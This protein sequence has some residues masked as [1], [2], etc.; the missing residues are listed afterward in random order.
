[1]VVNVTR[2][3]ASPY[4]GL[5]KGA[6][7]TEIWFGPLKTSAFIVV[8]VGAVC[9]FS[10]TIAVAITMSTLAERRLFAGDSRHSSCKGPV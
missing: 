4:A 5:G 8:G 1:M 7:S 6:A 3:T 2:K 9:G 10:G